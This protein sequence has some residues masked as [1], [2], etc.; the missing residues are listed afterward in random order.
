MARRRTTTTARRRRRLTFLLASC[1]L[2][3]WRDEHCT[4]FD[5]RFIASAFAWCIML[6]QRLRSLARRWLLGL[7]RWLVRATSY[8]SKI[9]EG[10]ITA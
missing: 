10:I 1:F 8:E 9:Q 6:R 4:T 3:S 2:S 7:R 5:S